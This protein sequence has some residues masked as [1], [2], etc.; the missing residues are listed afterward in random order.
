MI[1]I[2]KEKQNMYSFD[3]VRA[4][5]KILR[6]KQLGREEAQMGRIFIGLICCTS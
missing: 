3:V 2:L 5:S 6:Q 1:K 4:Y